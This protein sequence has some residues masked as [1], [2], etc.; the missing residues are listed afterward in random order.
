MRY[1]RRHQYREYPKLGFVLKFMADAVVVICLGVIFVQYILGKLSVSGNSMNPALTNEDV[2]FVNHF[3]YSFSSPKRYDIVAFN[4]TG[5]DTSKIYIKR[6]IGLPGETVQ[7]VDGRVYIDGE[8]LSDDVS[9]ELIIT[10]GLAANKITLGEDEYFVLGDN[11]NNSED[12]R[13]ANIG[14]IKE[15]NIIGKPWFI[16]SPFSRFGFI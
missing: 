7:I 3:A 6:V 12:S 10:A 16:L 1:N 14:S 13:F 11:R 9:E 4:V 15:K 2:I 5:K 8:P